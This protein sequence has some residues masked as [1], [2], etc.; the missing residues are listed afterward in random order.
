MWIDKPLDNFNY[1][2]SMLV[3][4]EDYDFLSTSYVF[5]ADNGTSDNGSDIG[6]RVKMAPNDLG[7]PEKTKTVLS[8]KTIVE[9]QPVQEAYILTA[10][11]D[12]GDQETVSASTTY[13]SGFLWDSGATWDSG[14]EWFGGST[15]THELF[16]NRTCRTIAPEW[17]GSG[18]IGLIGYVVNYILNEN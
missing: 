5:Q 14:E 17:T 2:T 9:N 15:D 1:G 7:Y 13:G 3:G 11:I 16:V 6:W 18:Q 4:D 12:Q 8:I 10:H